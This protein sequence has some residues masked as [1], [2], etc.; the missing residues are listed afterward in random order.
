VDDAA[1]N[2]KLLARL[3]ERRN[4][5]SCRPPKMVKRRIQKVMESLQKREPIRYPNGLRNANG[6]TTAS[7]EIRALGC[8]SLIVGVTG[9]AL[10]E[11]IAHFRSGA[12]LY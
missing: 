9:N 2:R 10:P 11:D 3:L 12:M 5:H 8:D 4:G 1:T 6:W 7:K